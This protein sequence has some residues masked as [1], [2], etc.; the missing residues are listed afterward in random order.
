MLQTMLNLRLMC[1]C[2]TIDSCKKSTHFTLFLQEEVRGQDQAVE[3]LRKHISIYKPSCGAV[4]PGDPIYLTASATY[5]SF[6][7]R[8][9]KIF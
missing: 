7:L 3:Q 8:L 2:Y 9:L 6:D 4:N 5:I 1:V